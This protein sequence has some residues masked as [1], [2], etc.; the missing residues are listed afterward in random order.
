MFH[1]IRFLFQYRCFKQTIIKKWLF[2]RPG[3]TWGQKIMNIWWC[4]I[5]ICGIWRMGIS[6]VYQRHILVT[7]TQPSAN[8]VLH[9]ISMHIIYQNKVQDMSKL[10]WIPKASVLSHYSTRYTPIWQPHLEFYQNGQCHIDVTIA[11]GCLST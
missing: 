4:I 11:F 8:L 1:N 9:R 10:E 2:N 7:I 6:I 5:K 3:S